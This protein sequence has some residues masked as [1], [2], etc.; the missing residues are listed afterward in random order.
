[1]VSRPHG[2]WATLLWVPSASFRKPG[3]RG[4]QETVL[5]HLYPSV[6]LRGTSLTPSQKAHR[7]GPLTACFGR[8]STKVHVQKTCHVPLTLR[9]SP[10]RGCFLRP[11]FISQTAVGSCGWEVKPAEAIGGGAG[12]GAGVGA[13]SQ[14]S[15]LWPFHRFPPFLMGVWHMETGQAQGASLS[16]PVGMPP[17]SHPPAAW[18]QHHGVQPPWLDQPCWVQSPHPSLLD[19]LEK[20][21]KFPFAF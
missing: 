21:G 7:M 16:R 20:V 3:T 19:H 1:M 12:M 9:T 18:G 2:L 4:E 13:A 15:T 17:I 8:Q 5:S 6:S 14:L 10:P 11:G